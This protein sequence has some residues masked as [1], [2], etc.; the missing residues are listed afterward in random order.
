MSHAG[1]MEPEAL[2]VVTIDIAWFKKKENVG[3]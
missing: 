1:I 3:S 2:I